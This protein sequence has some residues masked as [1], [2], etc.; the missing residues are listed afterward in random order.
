MEGGSSTGGRT[1]TR[2]EFAGL[3]RAHWSALWAVAAG[4]LGSRERA[5][6]ALQDASIV[7]LGKLG[8]FSPGTSF[9]HWM[10]QIVRYTAL[11]QARKHQ[12]G[13]ALGTVGHGEGSSGRNADERASKIELAEARAVSTGANQAVIVS[14]RGLG[15]DAD[16]AGLDDELS[17]ALGQVSED[18]RTCLIMRAVL[19]MTYKEIATCLG[20][21]ENTAMSHVHRAR[22][23]LQQHF[24]EQV[25]SGVA[26]G[27]VNN[28][29][30]DSR[31][32]GTTN[33]NDTRKNAGGAEGWEGRSDHGAR[34]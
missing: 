16:R 13:V 17:R 27:G 2:E 4:V 25:N 20:I 18:A 14:G 8:E 28:A 33:L 34:A 29:G 23:Q 10:S 6:D 32:A 22:K 24:G 3:L 21:P 26:K 19:E 5:T 12:R 30:G 15:V 31:R 11:N 1:V 9:V 7:A